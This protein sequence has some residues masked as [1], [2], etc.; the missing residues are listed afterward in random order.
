LVVRRTEADGVT[1][2]EADELDADDGVTRDGAKLDADDGV[3][4]DGADEL[5]ADDGVVAARCRPPGVIR[6]GRPRSDDGNTE[7]LELTKP[8]R[9]AEWRSKPLKPNLSV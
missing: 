1:R 8:K 4:R 9:T 6:Y 7:T 5:D 2:D 3:T